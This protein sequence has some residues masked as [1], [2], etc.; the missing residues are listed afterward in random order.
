M[1]KLDIRVKILILVIA[2][3]LMFKLMSLNLHLIVA[4]VFTLY[5]GLTSNVRRM[6]NFFLIYMFF[7]IYEL[8]F[9]HTITVKVIDSFL[10]LTTLMYK[11][12]YRIS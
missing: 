1:I 10:L 5:L 8:Y 6:M 2:N 4:I 11:T 7:T 9:S 12:L 3:I